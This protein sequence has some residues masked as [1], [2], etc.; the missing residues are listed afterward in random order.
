MPD[1]P[2]RR[3][4]DTRELML[5]AGAP[6]SVPARFVYLEPLESPPA[7]PAADGGLLEHWHIIRANKWS[8]VVLAIAGGLAAGAIALLQT[9]V[10][11]ARTSLEV[12]SVR[13][14]DGVA[15]LR[16]FSGG[17]TPESYL[18][19]QVRVLE[20]VS[21]RRRVVEKLKLEYQGREF[22]VRDRL[23]AVRS[24]LRMPPAE[25]RRTASLP[26]VNIEVKTAKD[27]R[28]IE[29]YSDSSDPAFAAKFANTM[30]NEYIDSNLEAL[31]DSSQRTTAWLTRQL[32]DMRKRLQDSEAQ[33]QAYGQQS[34]LIFA[35]EDKTSVEEQKLLQLQD[36]LLKAQ[37]DRVAKQSIYEIASSA[38]AESV[39][40]VVDNGQLGAL[41]SKLAEL[42]RELAELSAL[43]T[44]SHY[45][46]RRVQ[47][48]ISELEAALSRNRAN[49]L[50][51]IKNDFESSQL[52]EKLFAQDYARQLQQVAAKGRKTIYYGL[53]KREVETN[54]QLYDELLQKL[55]QLGVSSTLQASNIRVLDPAEPPRNPYKPNVLSMIL[56]GMTAGMAIGAGVVIGGEFVNR[57]L[58]APGEAAFHLKVPE[59]GVIPHSEAVNGMN[60]NGARSRMLSIVNPSNRTTAPESLELI[61]WQNRPS[62]IAES[63]RSALASV[64]SNRHHAG[65]S[66]VILITSAG[67]GEGK[68]STV[69]NLGI[70]LAEINQKVLLIDADLRKPRLHTI[71]NL[72]NSWGLSDLLRERNP[73][74]DYPFEGIAKATQIDGLY[75]LPGGPSAVSIANLFYS[76]R[77]V[78][79][80]E[81]LR[82]DFDT[83]L[84][85]TPPM[86]YLSDARVLGRLS[87]G[88][89]LVVRA[90]KTMRDDALSA[91]QRLLDDGIPVL[92]TI[93]NGWDPKAKARHGYGYGYPY[94]DGYVPSTE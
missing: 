71:Y 70:A 21:L 79:L 59:L 67:R 5:P 6:P 28:L 15:A 74:N 50:G 60:G 94:P 75:V 62:L 93:L 72:S 40:Q 77:M 27:S 83:V 38:P 2:Q 37:A 65:R 29:I 11:Q 68:S 84:V 33:L 56:M 63:F 17:F 32:D 22:A 43:F 76:G 25:P 92:G 81:R 19:T 14:S 52:R 54:R 51:R 45:R 88:A 12:Q 3:N 80:L 31:W 47:A 1:L 9:P 61:T 13:N 7:T 24:L 26:S 66:R 8:I 73:I 42:R 35:G 55:R 34:G 91:K 89:I 20:S 30:S 82:L 48:Q 23:A 36:E 64:L 44:P 90:G 57:S 78:E 87:D 49:I 58:R 4:D 41:Q 53:L 16:D 39:P 46:T 10:Y 69:S 18:Q 86:S 85:D